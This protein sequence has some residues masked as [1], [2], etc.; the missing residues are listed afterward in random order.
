MAR[1]MV[2]NGEVFNTKLAVKERC[3]AILRAGIPLCPEDEAFLLA[4]L[5]RHRDADRKRGVGVRRVYVGSDGYGKSCFWLERLDGSST[6]F[7]FLACITPPSHE[8]QA[9]EAFRQS[10]REQVS[11]YRVRVFAHAWELPCAITG[12]AVNY[13][14]AHV[15]HRPPD[16]F[17]ALLERFLGVQCL[18]VDDVRITPSHDGGTHH[19]LS[20]PQL[21]ARWQA[22]HKAN[23]VLQ[24]TS[25]RAN[26]SQGGRVP[27]AS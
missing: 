9:R 1:E 24:V 22:F 13:F 16:T 4:L 10:I 26:L 25:S 3:S 23:A 7:S 6:D 2:I 11:A 21:A 17:L 20:D 5:E 12:V 27:R 15:D 8:S 19:A 14:S 18:G